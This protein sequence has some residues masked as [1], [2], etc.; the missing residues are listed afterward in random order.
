MLE[1]F[2]I[3]SWL[4][5]LFCID[6]EMW[7][8]FSR[9]K[10]IGGKYLFLLLLRF[11]ETMFVTFQKNAA[12]KNNHISPP[13]RIKLTT[14]RSFYANK[15]WNHT[16]NTSILFDF[17]AS[18]WV[19]M[20]LWV[21]FWWHFDKISKTTAEHLQSCWLFRLI[22]IIESVL[23]SILVHLLLLG[24]RILLIVMEFEEG[25]SV[26]AVERNLSLRLQSASRVTLF[27]GGSWGVFRLFCID[28]EMLEVF[29]I[30]SWLLVVFCIDAEMLKGF[31]IGS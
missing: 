27:W 29:W 4:L 16:I 5:G 20:S 26:V 12:T 22:Q 18:G 2:W 28:A 1:G 24:F 30:G 17:W 15:L 10:K 31:W 14:T 6:A 21:L 9:G 25:S 3:G 13:D 11:S 19:F 23:L 8:G 7:R